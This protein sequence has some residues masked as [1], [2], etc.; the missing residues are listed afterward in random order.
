MRI[1]QEKITLLM[2]NGGRLGNQLWLMAALY[3]YGLEKDY[4]FDARCFFEYQQYFNIK[5]KSKVSNIIGIT[6]EFLQKT[7]INEEILRDVFYMLFGPSIKFFAKMKKDNVIFDNDE[8]KKES[9]RIFI[10]KIYKTT[11]RII[12]NTYYSI[13]KNK[14]EPKSAHGISQSQD[15]VSFLPPSTEI[16]PFINN[17]DHTYFYGWL[18]RNPKGIVKFQKE[19]REFFTPKDRYKIKVTNQVSELRKKYEH[20]VGVHVRLGDCVNEFIDNDRI[21]Y[22]EDEVLKILKEYVVFSGIKVENICF[23]I[24]SDGALSEITFNGFNVIITHNNPVEDIWILSLTDKI[25]GADSSFA[26]TA[27]LF[28]NIPFIV[29]KRGIDWDYYKDKNTFFVNKYVKR[30]IY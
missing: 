11:G 6:Y 27:S 16:D 2:H 3:S 1:R 7:K 5:T 19:I 30:F 25:V 18:F 23:I 26:I 9:L 28:G 4:E 21:A 13:A 22:S 8:I 10:Y 14:P 20:I 15:I 24:C 17:S 12:N 29:F